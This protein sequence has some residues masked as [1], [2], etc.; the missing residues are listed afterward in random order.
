QNESGYGS[1]YT[2]LDLDRAQQARDALIAWAKEAG[3]QDGGLTDLRSHG[4][5]PLDLVSDESSSKAKQT[6]DLNAPPAKG[7]D[8]A[9]VKLAPQLLEALALGAAGL[10]ITHTPARKALQQRIQ[11]WWNGLSLLPIAGALIPISGA[12]VKHQRVVSVF[13][14]P[15]GSL[16]FKLVAAQINDDCIDILVEQPLILQ[17]PAGSNWAELDLK[18]AL[19]AM[20]KAIEDLERDHFTLLLLD[21]SLQTNSQHIKKLT[22]EHRIMRNSQL[23]Q[24]L[25]QLSESDQQLLRQWL[26]KP[27]KTILL[28][29][30]SCTAVMN[31][32]ARSQEHWAQFMPEA[33]ANVA[34]VLELTIALANLSPSYAMI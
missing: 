27:S 11:G 1:N 5:P 34:G 8:P 19:E 26:N 17:A 32:L 25:T 12:T 29:N 4:Q 2:S 9:L 16:P 15:G 3:L 10:Y 22:D 23:Q 24:A 33:L 20:H 21:P 13:L 7:I 18:P 14:M 28:G 31:E 6:R 30:E